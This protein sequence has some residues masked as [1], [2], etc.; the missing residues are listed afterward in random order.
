MSQYKH[1]VVEPDT[2]LYNLRNLTVRQS[3]HLRRVL[4]RVAEHGSGDDSEVIAVRLTM[5]DVRLARQLLRED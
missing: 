1:T 4:E 3:E 2:L 5:P